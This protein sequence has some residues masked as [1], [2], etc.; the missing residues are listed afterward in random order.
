MEHGAPLI[1]DGAMS[2]E[3]ETGWSLQLPEC[4]QL[5]DVGACQL[6]A[7]RMTGFLP[8]H[9]SGDTPAS[10]LDAS[11][12]AELLLDASLEAAPQPQDMD[13][14]EGSGGDQHEALEGGD[15]HNVIVKPG[16]PG[17]KDD[18]KLRVGASLGASRLASR[19]A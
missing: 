14:G 13:R 4:L 1:G 16:C 9:G 2:G 5:P 15:H 7:C 3:E 8:A 17:F 19:S 6:Q 10:A 11:D 18:F 12:T